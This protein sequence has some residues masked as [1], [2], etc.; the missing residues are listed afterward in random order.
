M[1]ISSGSQTQP[2]LTV[3]HHGSP[4]PSPPPQACHSLGVEITMHNA[5]SPRSSSMYVGVSAVYTERNTGSWAM[6]LRLQ[7]VRHALT[8]GCSSTV[9]RRP[10]SQINAFFCEIHRPELSTDSWNG[11]RRRALNGLRVVKEACVRGKSDLWL[12]KVGSRKEQ[13]RIIASR[14]HRAACLQPA[15]WTAVSPLRAR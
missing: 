13:H 3:G 1:L 15:Q 10:A 7:T 11:A 12:V 5:K 9:G 8:H 2:T 6:F 4:M 14:C